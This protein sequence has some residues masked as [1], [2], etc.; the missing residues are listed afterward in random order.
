MYHSFPIFLYTKLSF[1]LS[2]NERRAPAMTS[3]ENVM[4][5]SFSCNR[6][7]RRHDLKIWCHKVFI[8]IRVS[9]LSVIFFLFFQWACASPCI[10]FSIREGPRTHE[11]LRRA[12][13]WNL[14]QAASFFNFSLLQV[15]L[16]SDVVVDSTIV[17]PAL[18]SNVMS[19]GWAWLK[20]QWR[21]RISDKHSDAQGASSERRRGWRSCVTIR[22]QLASVQYF[23]TIILL[24]KKG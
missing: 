5:V 10:P 11:K 7:P 15:I 8:L 12:D 19:N 13:R 6:V 18:S 21:S 4:R 23:V 20:A 17:V 9:N 1:S 2:Q 24:S 3:N 14:R 22:S 16:C